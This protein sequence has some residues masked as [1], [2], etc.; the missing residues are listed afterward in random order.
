MASPSSTYTPTAPEGTVEVL[1]SLFRLQKTMHCE[2]VYCND[3]SAS[4]IM[5][6]TCEPR[7]HNTKS[8][9]AAL[10]T[11]RRDQT[12]SASTRT[13]PA[14][15]AQIL[16]HQ[17][18]KSNIL[19]NILIIV[20]YQSILITAIHNTLSHHNNECKSNTLHNSN[21]NSNLLI[22]PY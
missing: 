20:I 4:G 7:S 2:K 8:G 11:P 3:P 21:N 18:S 19:C 17:H 15:N 9:P 14:V 5:K 13:P 12:I 1:S 22:N 10:T 6:G 16:K